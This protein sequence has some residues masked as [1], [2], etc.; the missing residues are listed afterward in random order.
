M[1]T[2]AVAQMYSLNN[3]SHDSAGGTVA[4]STGRDSYGPRTPTSPVSPR[5]SM[6]QVRRKSL[7]PSSPVHQRQQSLQLNG[8]NEHGTT[9][10][11]P[12]P[13]PEHAQ[14][15]SPMQ[16]TA[17]QYQQRLP[18]FHGR[19]QSVQSLE[20]RDLQ[21]PSPDLVLDA[22]R[23][24]D[25]PVQA[26]LSS[27]TFSHHHI[28]HQAGPMPQP[29]M[30]IISSGESHRSSSNFGDEGPGRES[31]ASQAS[32][33]EDARMYPQ[34]QYHH[35]QFSEN[36][37]YR[38]NNGSGGL[39]AGGTGPYPRRN[40]SS[41]TS[42]DGQPPS[43]RHLAAPEPNYRRDPSRS[44]SVYS[45]WSIDGRGR[46]PGSPHQRAVST[47]SYDSR[48]SSYTD[49]TQ[50]V[51]MQ[52]PPPPI[53]SFDN[54]HLR[55]KV[56]ANA[57]LLTN[58]QT[59]EMYRANAKKSQD[60]YLQ[61]ELAVFMIQ[62]AQSTGDGG[63]SGTPSP[64]ASGGK[65]DLNNPYEASSNASKN[66][67]LRE[68]RQ[69]LERLAGK[70]PQ[71]QYYLADAYASGLFNKGKEENE[72]AFQLF[73]AASKHGHAEAGYRAALC[74]EFGWGSRKDPLKAVQFYRQS[75]SKNHP[76]AMTRLGMA[77][78]RSDLGLQ[79]RYKEGVKWL[80][81][82]TDVADA[83]YPNAPYELGCMH[84]TGYGD[85]VFQDEGYAAQ[86]FTQ[87]AE[88]GHPDA[89][90]RMGDAYEHGKL[91]CPRDAALSVHFYT[92]AAQRGN[93]MAMMALCA[94]YLVG[95][96]PVLEKNEDEAYQ[97]ALK[98]S[99]YGLPKAEYAIGYFTEMGI[100]CRRDPLEANV[101]Y[102]K[103]AGH[104]DERAIAR[105]K[106]IQEAAS[107]GSPTKKDKK[108]EKTGSRGV[109]EKS[110]DTGDGDCII[111]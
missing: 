11:N 25:P 48:R 27:P 72:K 17:Q 54:S 19:V 30:A 84:E 68:A 9:H 96:A 70:L 78:L 18:T 85:D 36:G 20:S 31:P 66:E 108:K 83:Q 74:F 93:A 53:A 4:A 8:I 28:T 77:C 87:A 79:G 59:L 44:S 10:Q 46:S 95:A 52:A 23:E 3:S 40:S 105:L 15:D 22:R 67:T 33:G 106:V 65:G 35:N 34:L 37:A 16:G 92:G 62:A 90:Y 81:R 73:V 102:V 56:G 63:E 24:E 13:S 41:P 100:G 6:Q 43:G 82:A 42:S 103:A 111:M 75:A 91:S 94:W 45:S 12:Y 89:Y 38:E 1:T 29:Q 58:K 49:L 55:N 32:S 88:L 57:S 110:R 39:G 99:E 86:L 60:P 69:I 51:H 61:Y 2:A 64:R 101:W 76:G 21:T 71:A 47:H 14:H 26:P 5:N 107:G 98:A 97:W 80:K 104:G 7:P 109:L 50:P